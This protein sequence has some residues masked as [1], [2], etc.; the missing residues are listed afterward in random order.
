MLRSS[1]FNQVNG[2]FILSNL[3]SLCLS[4]S[5]RDVRLFRSSELYLIFSHYTSSYYNIHLLREI[6]AQFLLPVYLWITC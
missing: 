5:K 2:V 6:L 4:S 3:T 1:G